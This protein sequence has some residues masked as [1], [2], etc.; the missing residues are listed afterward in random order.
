MN[1]HRWLKDATPHV[2]WE[3]RRDVTTVTGRPVA[4]GSQGT[5]PA[6]LSRVSLFIHTTHNDYNLLIFQCN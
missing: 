2:M 1:C 6:K 3:L 4:A 5:L